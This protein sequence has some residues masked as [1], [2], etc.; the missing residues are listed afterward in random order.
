MNLKEKIKEAT[1]DLVDKNFPKGECKERG[2]A[3]VLYAEML[4]IIQGLVEEWG[5]GSSDVF[6]M[7]GLRDA[8]TQC[9]EE[10]EELK[11]D[12]TCDKCG[13][14]QG[15]NADIDHLSEQWRKKC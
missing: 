4:I 13:C 9:A 5:E 6:Y 3:I 12:Y 7:K 2:Q 15:L 14:P 8:I 1:I 10:L 11:V